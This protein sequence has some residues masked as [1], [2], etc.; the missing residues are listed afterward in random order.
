MVV[1]KFEIDTIGMTE[2]TEPGTETESCLDSVEG[3][4]EKTTIQTRRNQKVE[5]EAAVEEEEIVG[6]MA[7]RC[8]FSGPGVLLKNNYLIVV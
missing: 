7:V 8:S 4:E 2:E 6:L 1:I 5:D 3:L